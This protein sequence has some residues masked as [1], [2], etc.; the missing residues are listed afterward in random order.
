MNFVQNYKF[1]FSWTGENQTEHQQWLNE[2]APASDNN[3]MDNLEEAINFIISLASNPNS[4]DKDFDEV[5]AFSVMQFLRTIKSPAGQ[6]EPNNSRLMEYIDE[7]G[8]E[9]RK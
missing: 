6:Y 7:K 3:L 8:E 9:F 4:D 5:Q 2:T 1:K